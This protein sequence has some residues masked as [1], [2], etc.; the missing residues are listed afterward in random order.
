MMVRS[1]TSPDTEQGT[2][3]VI[4]QLYDRHAPKLLKEER[5]EI[6]WINSI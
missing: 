4:V 3:E 6:E 2:E 1:P 5:I